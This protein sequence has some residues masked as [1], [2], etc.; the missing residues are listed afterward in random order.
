[1]FYLTIFIYDPVKLGKRYGFLYCLLFMIYK[2]R[3]RTK[4]EDIVYS[5]HFY[6]NDPS[7]KNTFKQQVLYR[8]C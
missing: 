5:L 7:L 8:N 1:M 3:K 4:I 2:I 6:F